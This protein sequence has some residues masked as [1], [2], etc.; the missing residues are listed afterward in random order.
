MVKITLKL[1]KSV[2][3][4]AEVY[5]EKAK[6]E[7]RKLEGAMVAL[8]KSLIELEK[9]KKK[10]EISMKEAEEKIKEVRREK[11][12]YEKFHWFVSSEGFLCIGGRDATTNEV[13]IKKYTEQH[14]LVFHTDIAGSPFFVIKTES[15]KVGEA[16]LNEVSQATACYSKAWK[17]GLSVVD[18][19]YVNPEQVS[20]TAK[21][22]EYIPRGAFMIYG[23]KNYIRPEMKLAIGIK[24]GRIIGG[25]VNAVKKEADDYVIIKQGKEKASSIA[26]KIR[27]K[28]GK[29]DLDEIIRFLP[30][31]CEI[32]K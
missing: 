28:L 25:A 30:G 26:K 6:K 12:W 9:A 20:K 4:N 32:E 18:V 23:K 31:E 15:R 29:G 19:F 14:D 8:N 1:D 24:A 11:E 2:E 17:L 7:K 27:S 16:T 10:E 3:Q 5:F 13:V 22:G 21:P